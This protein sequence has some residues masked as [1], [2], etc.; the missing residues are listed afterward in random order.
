MSQIMGLYALHVER[1]TTSRPRMPW[2]ICA[3]GFTM[4]VQASAIHY[5]TPKDN[6]GPYTAFEVGYPSQNE[7]LL[8][9]YGYQLEDGGWDNVFAW[10]PATVVDAIIAKHG[11]V[12]HIGGNG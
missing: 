11:G 5:C 9:P 2:I 3:D 12:K 8:H 4:S 10:V 6:V 1:L 7:P